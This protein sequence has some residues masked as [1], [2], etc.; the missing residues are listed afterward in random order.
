M[1]WCFITVRNLVCFLL[2]KQPKNISSREDG[3]S[4]SVGLELIL[5]E[6]FQ[7]P[8]W[9][10]WQCLDSKL[11]SKA[12]LVGQSL[13]FVGINCCWSSNVR[14][15]LSGLDGWPMLI[16]LMDLDLW[17]LLL[18]LSQAGIHN[19]SFA[20]AV[21][22]RQ[23][24]SV[25]LYCSVSP[26]HRYHQAK[27]SGQ[28][29]GGHSKSSS[30]H[31][32]RSTSPGPLW[33]NDGVAPYKPPDRRSLEPSSASSAPSSSTRPGRSRNPSSSSEL[34][35]GSHRPLLPQP[36]RDRS[37]PRH[38]N[39]LRWGGASVDVHWHWRA[40]ASAAKEKADTH[41]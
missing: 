22:C 7:H 40:L 28:G 9:S 35:S 24:N 41:K 20:L 3:E 38:F 17:Y 31:S 33:R 10:L 1:C 19:F 5:K 4:R 8:N 15:K 14:G 13:L 6:L 18:L 16:W 2:E 21:M 37:E 34:D 29:Q 27:A 39:P 30:A 12:C 32:S 25:S 11:S 23:V 36:P 26:A